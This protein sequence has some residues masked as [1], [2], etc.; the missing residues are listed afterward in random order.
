[1]LILSKME[2]GLS[3]IVPVSLFWKTNW[4]G[5]TGRCHM[6]T[7]IFSAVMFNSVL[8]K[9][10]R[11]RLSNGACQQY[12]RSPRRGDDLNNCFIFYRKVLRKDNA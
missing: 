3:S 11:I 12:F 2:K 4:D 5:R 8:C 9:Y 10:K 7:L 1:M 6:K